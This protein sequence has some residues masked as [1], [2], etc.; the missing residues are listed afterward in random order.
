MH[1]IGQESLTPQLTFRI[2]FFLLD[3]L[4]TTLSGTLEP[5]T[6]VFD[7][8]NFLYDTFSELCLLQAEMMLSGSTLPI[9]PR[10]NN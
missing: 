5:L 7:T 8:W 6:S 9:W 3:S 10:T 4:T 1:P 2:E